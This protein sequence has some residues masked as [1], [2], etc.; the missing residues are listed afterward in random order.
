MRQETSICFF[1]R[2]SGWQENQITV[3]SN[4][5]QPFCASP[6]WRTSITECA[7]AVVW[8]PT[9]Q[10]VNMH[11]VDE[12]QTISSS[13]WLFFQARKANGINRIFPMLV[14]PHTRRRTLIGIKC[15]IA[16][17][18]GRLTADLMI[19][20]RKASCNRRCCL[21]R[22]WEIRCAMDMVSSWTPCVFWATSCNK[23]AGAWKL[24]ADRGLLPSSSSSWGRRWRFAVSCSRRL[25]LYFICCWRASSRSFDVMGR[26]VDAD[27]RRRHRSSS[28]SLR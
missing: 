25:A 16:V 23:L 4:G 24:P 2:H 7:D 28:F 8:M 22:F 5:N 18:R 21:L 1:S 13:R 26:R 14:N 27:L 9:Q 15:F 12:N 6:F 3:P 19:F 20:H 17:L 10:L 11:F